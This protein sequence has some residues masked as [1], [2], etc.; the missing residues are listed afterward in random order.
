MKYYSFSHNGAGLPICRFV[1]DVAAF[2]LVQVK[3]T[4][5]SRVRKTTVIT[6]AMRAVLASASGDRASVA[7][8]IVVANSSCAGGGMIE[9][10]VI[11]AAGRALVGRCKYF[12]IYFLIGG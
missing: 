3:I 11:A 9:R 7:C 8:R 5:E 1:G 6:T 10:L 2:V 12:L 4:T